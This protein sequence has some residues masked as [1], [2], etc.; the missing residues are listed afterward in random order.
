M[1]PRPILLSDWVWLAVGLSSL[2][3]HGLS[4]SLGLVAFFLVGP[5]YGLW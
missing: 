3:A 1:G 5:I 2:L 4:N